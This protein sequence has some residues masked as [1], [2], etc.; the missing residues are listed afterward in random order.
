MP[1]ELTLEQIQATE[2]KFQPQYD[3]MDI[4]EKLYFLEKFVLTNLEDKQPTPNV[5]NVTLNDPKT[6]A[7][8]AISALTKAEQ[9]WDI[10]GTRVKADLAPI[11][12]FGDHALTEI[13]TRLTNMGEVELYPTQCERVCIRGSIAARVGVRGG[14]DGTVIWDV[15]PWDTR[16][17]SFGVAPDGM[18]H[19]SYTTTKSKEMLQ[20]EHG[21]TIKD[22][23]AVVRDVLTRTK[24]IV[25][26]ND[27]PNKTMTHGLGYVPVVFA[28]SSSGTTLK[29]TDRSGDRNDDI[30][31][32]VRDLY[33][34]LNICATVLQTMNL[35]SFKRPLQYESEAGERARLPK[36]PPYGVGAVTAVEKGGGFK[37]MPLED[38][39]NATR[40]IWQILEQRIE[41]GS[42]TSLD[43]GSTPFPMSAVGI[44]RLTGEKDEIFIPRLQA[45]AVFYQKLL[46]MIIKQVTL[47]DL[48]PELGIMGVKKLWTPADL[49]G[50]YDIKLHYYAMSPEQN[51][52]NYS[53][54]A[55][56]GETVSM[57]YKRAEIIKL[58]NPD[59]MEDEV[60]SE[61]ADK[62]V[63]TLRLYKLAKS[64]IKLGQDVEATLIANQM[65]LT[66]DQ[67]KSGK[68]EG[69]G[70]Q[71][72]NSTEH[73][74]EAL[75]A[76]P[77]S[78]G[79]QLIPLLDSGN[80]PESGK[81]PE[82]E[83]SEMKT[84]MGVS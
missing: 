40:M 36:R 71:D 16:F 39:M 14:K 77:S 12:E 53:V 37:T 15:M 46:R 57:R 2:A 55:A 70:G 69:E 43:Y 19:A 54:A 72:M 29:T 84:K 1:D 9:V 8:K 38:I 64:K 47:M 80:M 50:D 24:E 31:S 82:K 74:G 68:L 26:L 45:L 13:D 75:K 58:K 27:I 17:F 28:G 20:F 22:E 35:M 66:L 60:N 32:S 5:Q 52:A 76:P 78:D 51:I 6:Y 83:A 18:T 11:E 33:E 4:S 3:R 48:K 61:L 44:A 59:A 30:Y 65:G 56:A 73:D 67:I 79:K 81:S 21:I 63:P 25:Y 23:E 41:R 34:Q 49:A 10:T 7:K 62:L 42:F